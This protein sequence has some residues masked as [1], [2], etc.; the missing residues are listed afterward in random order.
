ML[1]LMLVLMLKLKNW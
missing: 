1:I